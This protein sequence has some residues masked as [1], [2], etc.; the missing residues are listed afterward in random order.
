MVDGELEEL[1]EAINALSA[2]KG[3]GPV[4]PDGVDLISFLRTSTGCDKKGDVASMDACVIDKLSQVVKGTPYEVLIQSI[5]DRAF[6]PTG[7]LALTALLDNFLLTR[8]CIQI[9]DASIEAKKTNTSLPRVKFGGV[10]TYDFNI[11]PP[12][13]SWADPENVLSAY[14]GR[15]RRRMVGGGSSELLSSLNLS[16]KHM[17]YLQRYLSFDA[18][19]S[20]IMI[21]GATRERFID[22]AT[23]E[24]FIDG[25]ARKVGAID[26]ASIVTPTVTPKLTGEA[27]V[28]TFDQLQFILNT[29]HRYGGGIHWVAV[30]ISPIDGTT[31]YFDSYGDPPGQGTVVGTDY[32]GK[33][34]FETNLR[35]WLN[36][37]VLTFSKAGIPMKLVWGTTCHQED[38]DDNNCGVYSSWYL[39]Q[40]SRGVPLSTINGRR[41]GMKEIV[42]YRD[43]LYKRK[44]NYDAVPILVDSDTD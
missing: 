21:G 42:K 14:L 34:K 5:R 10:L 38:A 20:G 1:R 28:G 22:G 41:V 33:D 2:K 9:E 24:R 32:R 36:N 25:G 23:G 39:L 4:I 8:I 12:T 13:T 35:E 30:C 19:K 15:P 44:A 18:V 40:R 26:I 31:E 27:S 16:P 17:S 7:P 6:S 43:V 37:I 11:P 3:G 29:D